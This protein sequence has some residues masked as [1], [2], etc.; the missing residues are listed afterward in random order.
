MIRE[1]PTLI[2]E[3]DRKLCLTAAALGCTTCKELAAAFRQVNERTSFGVERAYKWLQGR[4]LPREHG[5]YADWMA[6]LDLGRSET[7]LADCSV[8]MFLEALCAR[9]QLPQELVRRRAETFAGGA[10]SRL[11]EPHIGG[12]RYLGG[13]FAAY[14]HAWSPY[15]A[16]RIIRG[17]LRVSAPLARGRLVADYSESLPTARVH[18]RGPALLSGR[19]L[20]LLLHE[21]GSDMPLF[22]TL[23]RPAPPASVLAGLVSGATFVGH[24][25]RPSVSRILM[26]RQPGTGEAGPQNERYMEAGESIAADLG[27]LGLEIADP[28]EVD[29]RVDAFLRG[30]TAAGLDQAVAEDYGAL[31]ALFDRLAIGTRTAAQG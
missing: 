8:E 4:A 21:Q 12:N 18:V 5:V 29:A 16:G 27:T 2:R 23:F 20:Y 28:D 3:F 19:S 24:D 15:F 13:V 7:W 9:R 25:P 14:S 6:L 17:T 10:V 22:F 1:P 26:I 30:A 11:D 31:V